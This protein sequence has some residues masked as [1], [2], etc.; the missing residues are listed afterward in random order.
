MLTHAWRHVEHLRSK[1]QVVNGAT[2]EPRCTQQMNLTW[3]QR[4]W[5]KLRIRHVRGVAFGVS[6]R[7]LSI[8][9]FH[10]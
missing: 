2:C 6:P 10:T 3:R 9:I 5:S 4:G 1:R 8:Y 7:S